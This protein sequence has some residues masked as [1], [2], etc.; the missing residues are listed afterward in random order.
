MKRAFTEWG[1]VVSLV[2]LVAIGVFWVGSLFV[3]YFREPLYLG[4]D[5][6]VRIENSRLCIFSELS[7]HWK[8]RLGGL[9]PRAISWV[10]VYRIWLFP[11]FEYHNRLF[12]NGRSIWSLEM[13]LVVPVCV[14]LTTMVILWRV[15]L[16]AWRPRGSLNEN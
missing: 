4:P 7:A 15:R 1:L 6:F 5:L 3:H 13:S 10:R 2:L 14:L 11:G 16:G 12:A 8:P 9:E